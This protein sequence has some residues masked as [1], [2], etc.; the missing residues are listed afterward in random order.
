MSQSLP[1]VTHVLWLNATSY[2]KNCLN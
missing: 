2:Q 1:S